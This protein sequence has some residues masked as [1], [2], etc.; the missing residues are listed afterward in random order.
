MMAMLLLSKNS[1]IFVSLSKTVKRFVRFYVKSS[2]IAN[3]LGRLF[4]KENRFNMKRDKK[5][6]DHGNVKLLLRLIEE[7]PCIYD[8]NLPSYSTKTEVEKAWKKISLE[9]NETRKR[10]KLTL[11]VKLFGSN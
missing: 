8:F 10:D 7:N 4:C 11:F 6:S 2:A 3:C 9:L 1:A 5:E